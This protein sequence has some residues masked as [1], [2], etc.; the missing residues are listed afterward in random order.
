[1]GRRRC[2]L[3]VDCGS[4]RRAVI[5]C[6]NSREGAA[7]VPT[8]ALSLCPGRRELPAPFGDDSPMSERSSDEDFA[9]VCLRLEGQ[10]R[11]EAEQ[12]G[13]WVNLSRAAAVVL[14]TAAAA[15]SAAGSASVFADSATLGGILAGAGALA[16]AIN[17]ALRP[18]EHEA[19][20]LKRWGGPIGRSRSN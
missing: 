19:G 13:K 10:A 12:A 1:L 17:A 9:D 8:E 6:C 16:A 14:L 3:L 4:Q 18:A 2:L 20:H 11:V 5:H 7:P 15:L